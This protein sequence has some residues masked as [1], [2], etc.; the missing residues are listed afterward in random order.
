[1]LTSKGI[2]RSLPANIPIWQS[3]NQNFILILILVLFSVV[4]FAIYM[5]YQVAT[6]SIE[7][8]DNE[9]S[10]DNPKK[11]PNVE[12]YQ[13]LL[14]GILKD[15]KNNK[16]LKKNY[17][18]IKL[19]NGQL[20]RFYN[21]PISLT[22]KGAENVEFYPFQPGR[23]DTKDVYPDASQWAYQAHSKF[24]EQIP[25]FE[26]KEITN[27]TSLQRV[28]KISGNVFGGDNVMLAAIPQKTSQF[29]ITKD[30]DMD[31]QT[32]IY[33]NKNNETNLL[34]N[35][36]YTDEKTFTSSKHL[37]ATYLFIIK[38]TTFD[39]QRLKTN[40]NFK[41]NGIEKV[42]KV[43]GDGLPYGFNI[44]LKI[45]KKDKISNK[46]I[47]GIAT[48]GA[49]AYRLY[50]DYSQKVEIIAKRYQ[51][52]C[53]HMVYFEIDGPKSQTTQVG[54]FGPNVSSLTLK[55]H[56]YNL[57]TIETFQNQTE[58]IP[59]NVNINLSESSENRTFLI[60]FN[61]TADGRKS[62]I[63]TVDVESKT[64][65]YV[66]IPN[67]E[68][69]IPI[70][71]KASGKGQALL[72]NNVDKNTPI[73]FLGDSKVQKIIT[74]KN[75]FLTSVGKEA[76]QHYNLFGNQM[77]F[78]WSAAQSKHKS[79]PTAVPTKGRGLLLND[80]YKGLKA[81]SMW[82][83]P[84]PKHF[85]LF[86]SFRLTQDRLLQG[87]LISFPGETPRKTGLEI[88]VKPAINGQ[89]NLRIYIGDGFYDAE[90]S[91]DSQPHSLL[92]I[93][94]PGNLE[95]YVDGITGKLLARQIPIDPPNF[96]SEPI[97]ISKDMGLRDCSL[98][99]LIAYKQ[100]DNSKV[101]QMHTLSMIAAYQLVDTERVYGRHQSQNCPISMYS[102]QNPCLAETWGDALALTDQKKKLKDYCYAHPT[103]PV[104]ETIYPPAQEKK[105]NNVQEAFDLISSFI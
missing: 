5:F 105:T 80:S 88:L 87:S 30:D 46:R 75:A 96:N 18:D 79:F 7:P 73:T 102:E 34:K 74:I 98:L 32:G 29:I 21:F 89:R 90:L 54:S 28:W 97:T 35:I 86:I 64:P 72:P 95:I 85:A 43:K 76:N 103:D 57:N 71:P 45:N 1:M 3:F 82:G 15:V 24:P 55:N 44:D 84:N 40:Y 25:P 58:L 83:T 59:E 99:S 78:S 101:L 17:F 91:F 52:K 33:Y 48:G 60:P 51:P 104:C 11:L 63:L 23:N 36:V 68:K 92:L 49:D 20:Q 6:N 22:I 2:T 61:G 100:I 67:V 27:P 19:E 69:P 70:Q 4:F 53:I 77:V 10:L 12:H 39:G 9:F 41:L 26:I 37:N 16:V 47:K 14:S 13:I 62:K 66:S 38:G 81:D 94:T 31:Y 50:P 93:G 56:V 42:E 65:L 8:F